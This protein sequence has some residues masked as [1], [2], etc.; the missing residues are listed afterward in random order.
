MAEGQEKFFFN[1]NKESAVLLHRLMLEKSKFASNVCQK[2]LIQENKVL[3]Y[4]HANTRKSKTTQAQI[5]SK[6][7]MN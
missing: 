6:C 5:P 2:N 1:L 3:L 7:L 4:T